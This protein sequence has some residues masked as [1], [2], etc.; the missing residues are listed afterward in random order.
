MVTLLATCRI[1]VIVDPDRELIERMR[2]L[3]EHCRVLQP[4][5]RT[6]PFFPGYVYRGKDDGGW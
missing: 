1:P 3:R 2:W 6:A 4:L 5:S